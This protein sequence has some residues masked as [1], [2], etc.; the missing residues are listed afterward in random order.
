MPLKTWSRLLLL[1]CI[2]SCCGLCT[3]VPAAVGEQLLRPYSTAIDVLAA[4]ALCATTGSNWW[5]QDA[6]SGEASPCS[7]T[8]KDNSR[9]TTHSRS[10]LQQQQQRQQQ[11]AAAAA[12]R[13][14]SCTNYRKR[15]ASRIYLPAAVQLAGNT[16][17]AQQQPPRNMSVVVQ[18][19]SP[20]PGELQDFANQTACGANYACFITA[21]A[22]AAVI[23]G[24][25]EVSGEGLARLFVQLPTQ[26][27]AAAAGMTKVVLTVVADPC[28]RAA[29]NTTLEVAIETAAPT[30]SELLPLLLQWQ[31]C[32]ACCC[33]SCW[34]CSTAACWGLAAGAQFCSSTSTAGTTRALQAQP[35]PPIQPNPHACTAVHAL[36]GPAAAAA[37]PHAGRQ[38]LQ[39]RSS[40]QQ[41]Y[42][43]LQHQRHGSGACSGGSNCAW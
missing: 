20:A 7:S 8:S 29:V 35:H 40:L 32:Y 11:P 43:L 23:P 4:A 1:I 19:A 41:P 39:D 6:P 38:H 15:S 13:T 5:Y 21:E 9:G 17:S 28:N 22:P 27:E 26:A 34:M 2:W 30:V 33:R 10:L 14:A 12:H 31:C 24:S 36:A 16:S 37:A 18:L 42:C 3:A 25:M